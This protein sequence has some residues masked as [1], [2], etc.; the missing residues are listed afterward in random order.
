MYMIPNYYIR[1]QEI[2]LTNNGKLDRRGL[3]DP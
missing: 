2:P 3:P 1:I